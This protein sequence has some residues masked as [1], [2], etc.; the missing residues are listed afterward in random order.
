MNSIYDINSRD[1]E[2]GH[3]AKSIMLHTDS[4]DTEGSSQTARD[5]T[6]EFEVLEERM[7]RSIA[8]RIWMREVNLRFV[9]EIE[10]IN[11][12]LLSAPFLYN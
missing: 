9:Q 4:V 11:T 1:I 7:Y 10:S 2:Q 5:I 8:F 6:G 3:G 12:Q